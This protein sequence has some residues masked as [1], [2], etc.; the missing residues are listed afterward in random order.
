MD[1]LPP[2]WGADIGAHAT[3]AEQNY[4]NGQPD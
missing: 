1:P 3:E 2:G 4:P